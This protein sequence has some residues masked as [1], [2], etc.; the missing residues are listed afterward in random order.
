M[1][2][3]AAHAIQTSHTWAIGL[4]A[5]THGDALAIRRHCLAG[6]ANERLAVMLGS[7]MLFLAHN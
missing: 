7:P 3:G 4:I 2:S 6:N 5:G 1:F